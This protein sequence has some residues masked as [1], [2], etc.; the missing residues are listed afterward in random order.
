MTLGDFMDV[1]G[2]LHKLTPA[3]RR[4]VAE[5]LAEPEEVQPAAASEKAANPS[6]RNAVAPNHGNPYHHHEIEKLAGYVERERSFTKKQ[7]KSFLKAYAAE[8]GRKESAL[9]KLISKIRTG[10]IKATK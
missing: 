10:K 9:P 1:L 5:V 2:R 8:F 4:A 6:K 7:K 3:Q